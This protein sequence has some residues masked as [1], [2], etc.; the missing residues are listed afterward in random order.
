MWKRQKSFWASEPWQVLVA[1]NA[2]PVGGD[3]DHCAGVVAEVDERTVEITG[4][5]NVHVVGHAVQVCFLSEVPLC[6]G[7]GL[8]GERLGGLGVEG[9]GEVIATGCAVELVGHPATGGTADGEV[10][11]TEGVGEQL[12]ALVCEHEISELGDS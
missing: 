10:D 6:F 9:T 2:V 1:S 8:V 11:V 5:T 12:D 3:V 7:H 4:D